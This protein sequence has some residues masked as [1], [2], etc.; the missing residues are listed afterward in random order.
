MYGRLT[1]RSCAL[2]DG[3]YSNAALCRLL[4]QGESCQ[5]CVEWSHACSSCHNS[6]L[7]QKWDQDFQVRLAAGCD[8]SSTVPLLI[9]GQK[10]LHLFTQGDQTIDSAWI[11]NLDHT[12]NQVEK[13]LWDGIFPGVCFK[14]SYNFVRRPNVL[15]VERMRTIYIILRQINVILPRNVS[16]QGSLPFRVRQDS[17]RMT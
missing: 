1:D 17:L 3:L 7:L 14:T 2:L 16:L 5:C 11:L 10:H 4:L 6:V 9:W 8:Q 12:K 13:L 15:Q